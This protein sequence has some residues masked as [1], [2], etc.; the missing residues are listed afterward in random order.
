MIISLKNTTCVYF[1]G[2]GQI[3]LNSQVI[4][5]LT[6]HNV[7][8]LQQILPPNRSGTPTTPMTPDPGVCFNLET[9]HTSAVD[10]FERKTKTK[11]STL[12]DLKQI[13]ENCCSILKNFFVLFLL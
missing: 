2:A 5:G 7:C 9:I 1:F 8:G 11:F 6:V 13:C 4:P 12:L 3:T 10:N